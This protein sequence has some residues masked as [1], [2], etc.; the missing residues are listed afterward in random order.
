[1][2]ASVVWDA[3]PAA[4]GAGA[5]ASDIGGG[6]SDAG[7]AGS[8]GEIEAGGSGCPGCVDGSADGGAGGVAGV[9]VRVDSAA[10]VGAGV[11]WEEDALLDAE[12]AATGTDTTVSTLVVGRIVIVATNSAAST[13]I[14]TM[15]IT[16]HSRVRGRRGKSASDALLDLPWSAPC[17]GRRWAP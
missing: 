7:V 3:E 14:V 10:I 17:R 16:S 12:V 1:M 8:T 15:A 9:V 13:T 6:T 11:A 5:G 4:G 2:A